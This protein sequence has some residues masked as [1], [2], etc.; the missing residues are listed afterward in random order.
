M[1]AGWSPSESDQLA[2]Q[3]E[4]R[5]DRC[6]TPP[7]AAFAPT[8]PTVKKQAP[9]GLQPHSKPP[10]DHYNQHRMVCI[11][12]AAARSV[13]VGQQCRSGALR[14]AALRPLVHTAVQ[15]RVSSSVRQMAVVAAAAGNGAATSTRERPLPRI[16]SSRS[17]ARVGCR[18]AA[19]SGRWS[20]SVPPPPLPAAGAA[21][22]ACQPA[23]CCGCCLP[24][25]CSP[26]RDSAG[27]E[28][29]PGQGGL[30]HLRLRW[31]AAG[32]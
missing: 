18:S 3:P 10:S 21:A 11:A 20:G 9:S 13:V 25:C 19:A 32:C 30:L 8:W 17:P 23:H 2:Q 24:C 22:T 27:Q 29:H 5:D 28:G 16:L 7:S 6:P 14:S 15:R 31:C 1:C 4:S 12:P 26:A